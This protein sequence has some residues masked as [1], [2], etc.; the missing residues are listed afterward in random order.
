[1]AAAVLGVAPAGHVAQILQ[2]V[3]QQHNVVGVH[4][5]RLGQL[6]LGRAVVVAQVAEGHHEAHVDAQELLGATAVDLLGQAREQDHRA[7]VGCVE[8]GR[9]IL[10]A[11]NALIIP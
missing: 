8:I 2:L 9:V 10:L 1:M 6:L 4:A 7:E 11:H 5:E 3:E